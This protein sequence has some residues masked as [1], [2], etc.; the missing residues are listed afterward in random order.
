MSTKRVLAVLL[1]LVAYIHPT[2]CCVGQGTASVG[3]APS[4]E[5]Y[6]LGDTVNVHKCGRLF[7]AG[8][9]LPTD[10][11]IIK[12]NSITR[13]ITL[14]TDGEVKWDEKQLLEKAGIQFHAIP[15]RSPESLTD[16]VFDKVRDLLKEQTTTTLFHCGSANRVGGVWIPFRVLD[17]DVP[18]ETAIAEAKEIGLKTEF[19][20][21]KAIAYIEKKQAAENQEESV[22]PGINKSFLDPELEVDKF[23]KRFEVES[24][25][26]YVARNEI[27]AACDIKDGNIVADVGSG[28]GLFTRMFSK[29]VGKAG[30]V[31]AV[32]ISPRLLEH[33]NNESSTYENANIT[34]ILCAENSSNLPP[35]SVDVVFI[36]DTYHH[37]EYPKST[38]ASIHR[39]LK[40]GGHLIVIDFERIEGK[41]REWLMNHVRA[42]KDVFRAEIQDAGFTLVDEKKVS[43]LKENY[44]LKFKK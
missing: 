17:Q 8:Q 44:F 15:F 23:L 41:T 19:V 35:N 4:V 11:D 7:T 40:P 39:A 13:V 26:I 34:G 43:G 28:T 2:H 20:L 6:R 25:E 10:L 18:L 36:C 21:E 12:K 30:W 16:E 24:R 1:I 5:D 27:L 37:F 31:Y 32:D 22:K 33:I 42:G 29:T 14:R 3:K 38:M 9:F